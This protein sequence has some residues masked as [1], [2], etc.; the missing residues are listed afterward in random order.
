M[1][2]SRKLALAA[3]AAALVGMGALAPASA[4]A[5]GAVTVSNLNMRA[6]PGTVYP[7]V[8]VLPA[9]A[10]VA[11]YGCNAGTT[12]CDV[13]FGRDRGWVSAN[14]LQVT[15]QNRTVVVTPAIAPAIGLGVVTYNQ[16]Y[17]N[18]YYVGRPWYGHWNTYYR[19]A[20]GG[21]NGNGCGAVAVGPR[22]VAVGGCND[23]TCGG[24]V[25]RR[26]PRGP[27]VRHGSFNRP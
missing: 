12:W 24:A 9:N 17:W 16:A 11:L 21:C 7:V 3:G 10:S 26:T 22:G 19:R 15:Y 20:A 1:K 8:R 4:E 14:Y 23:V 25:V 2:R 18:T 5:A 27:V 13:G 6:G